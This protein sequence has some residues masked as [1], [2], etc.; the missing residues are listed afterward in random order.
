L[1]KRSSTEILLKEFTIKDVLLLLLPM[2]K[3]QE[4]VEQKL[5]SHYWTRD[6]FLASIDIDDA[7]GSIY[8]WSF[9]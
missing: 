2:G 7:H 3:H 6:E 1:L 8:K 4:I 5:N 9:K